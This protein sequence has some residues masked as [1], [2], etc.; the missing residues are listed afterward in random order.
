MEMTKWWNFVW[1]VTLGI[2]LVFAFITSCENK[3]VGEAKQSLPKKVEQFKVEIDNKVYTANQQI[4]N[5]LMDQV[6][7][8]TLKIKINNMI[9]RRNMMWVNARDFTHQMTLYRHGVISAN[10]MEAIAQKHQARQDSLL[11]LIQCR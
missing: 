3:G 8:D 11:Q 7:Q 2:M 10:Q 1:V 6:K 5:C 9:S 4:T